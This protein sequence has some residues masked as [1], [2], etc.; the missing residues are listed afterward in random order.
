MNSLINFPLPFQHK[1]RDVWSFFLYV[2][3]I[4]D[5]LQ[6]IPIGN[7]KKEAIEIT[8]KNDKPCSWEALNS[9]PLP[10]MGNGQ[11]V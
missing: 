3:K 4:I 1:S 11:W 5:N 8:C 9:L 7:S 10:A 6:K 2:K